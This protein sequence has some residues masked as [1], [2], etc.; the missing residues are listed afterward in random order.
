MSNAVIYDFETLSQNPIDGV[1]L[2]MALV[3]FD[4]TRFFKAG[5]LYTYDELLHKTKYIKFNVEDQVKNWGRKIQKDTLQ[6]WSERSKE[7]QELLKPEPDDKS[8]SELYSFFIK[9][10]KIEDLKV[11]YTRNNTFDPIFL[12]SIVTQT[13]HELPYKWWLIRD[14]KSTINGMTWGQN[15]IRDNFIPP[16][17]EDHFVA[18]DPR[19]DVVMD[20]MRLQY[21]S[22]ILCP[23]D[24]VPW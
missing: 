19:H 9:H 6:W 20:V 5:D 4:S 17:L 8:I 14:T 22:N 21:L 15:D 7:A 1:V 13:G 11:V 18:H 2:C 23:V 16:G 3:T 12:N 10:V 24:E